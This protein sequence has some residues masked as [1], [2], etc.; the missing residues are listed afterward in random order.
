MKSIFLLIAILTL[1][2]ISKDDVKPLLCDK[3][4][5]M[6]FLVISD[7]VIRI[8]DKIPDEQRPWV[9]FDSKGG[10]ENELKGKKVT[11]TWSYR[12]K[13]KTITTTEDYDPPV[14]AEMNLIKLTQDSLV[15][16]IDEETTLGF[17]YIK[18]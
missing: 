5:I 17:K 9:R 7:S 15:L 10:F 18:P 3:K 8:P 11:G 14:I 4:W 6:N 2:F 1:G 12:E 13:G 16:R